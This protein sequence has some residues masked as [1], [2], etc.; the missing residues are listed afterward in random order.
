LFDPL[1]PPAQKARKA[2]V[3]ESVAAAQ[4]LSGAD[5]HHQA[6]GFAGC[7]SWRLSARTAQCELV[8]YG[9]VFHDEHGRLLGLVTAEV[10]GNRLLAWSFRLAMR[11][12]AAAKVDR[13]RERIR[14]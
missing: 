2:Q 11:S 13:V 12:M 14:R 8:I 9:G 7:E 10:F 6:D 4:S 1:Q 3:P 5:Q